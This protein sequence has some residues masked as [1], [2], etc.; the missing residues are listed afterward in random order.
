MN[1]ESGA[2]LQEVVVAYFKVLSRSWPENTDGNHESPSGWL[3]PDREWNAGHIR[4]AALTRSISHV[5]VG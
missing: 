3:M 5:Y 1:N 2:M 4:I